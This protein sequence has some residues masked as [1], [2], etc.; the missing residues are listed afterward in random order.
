MC[1][2][3][4]IDKTE[5]RRNITVVYLVGVYS[6]KICKH[7]IIIIEYDILEQLLRSIK[8]NSGRILVYLVL[9]TR[10]S[11]VFG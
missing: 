10:F 2:F 4:F 7:L 11:K 1:N 5:F 8:N 9:V 3:S 6:N